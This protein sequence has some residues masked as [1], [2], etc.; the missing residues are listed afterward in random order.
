MA[1][2]S[3]RLEMVGDGVDPEDRETRLIAHEKAQ[4]LGGELTGAPAR[5]LPRKQGETARE[6]LYGMTRP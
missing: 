6:V 4:A 2:Q 3:A 1:V 5:V